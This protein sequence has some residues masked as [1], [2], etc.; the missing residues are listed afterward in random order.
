M[1]STSATPSSRVSMTSEF[2]TVSPLPEGGALGLLG[3]GLVTETV[4]L[5]PGRG[6]G[7]L[8]L[9]GLDGAFPLLDG[10]GDARTL[11]RL[12]GVARSL[13]ERLAALEICVGLRVRLDVPHLGVGVG[14]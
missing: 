11:P 1:F 13:V 10:L 7:Q 2:T 3:R 4:D 6:P 5:V 8:A 14:A 9:A 12:A